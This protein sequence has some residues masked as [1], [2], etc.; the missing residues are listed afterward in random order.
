[1]CNADITAVYGVTVTPFTFAGNGRCYLTPVI[2]T[3][4]LGN[5]H[6]SILLGIFDTAITAA[7]HKWENGCKNNHK[8]IIPLFQEQGC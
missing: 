7:S 4:I 6:Y 2:Y 8:Y 1:M 3:A 5:C